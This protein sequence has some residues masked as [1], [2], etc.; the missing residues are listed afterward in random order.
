MA[1]NNASASV[2]SKVQAASRYNCLVFQAGC[3]KEDEF[4]ET[5]L[6]IA[7]NILEDFSISKSI[8]AAPADISDGS[9][10]Y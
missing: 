3:S 9:E 10:V 6:G 8:A 4:Y 5:Y 1:D 2:L 7:S